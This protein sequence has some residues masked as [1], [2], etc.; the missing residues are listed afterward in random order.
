[1]QTA[2]DFSFVA[3]QVAFKPAMP[4]IEALSVLILHCFPR[5]DEFQLNP[6]L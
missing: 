4:P 6:F 1:M 5:H 3:S 2:L